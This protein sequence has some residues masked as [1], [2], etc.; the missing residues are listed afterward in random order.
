M[1]R[2]LS[3]VGQR[4]EDR[5]CLDA[6]VQPLVHGHAELEQAEPEAVALGFSIAFHESLYRERGKQAMGR[7]LF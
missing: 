3:A 1:D 6:Y 7:A 2:L 4:S 5:Q